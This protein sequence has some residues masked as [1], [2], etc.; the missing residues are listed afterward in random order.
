MT[1]Q[2]NTRFR[3]SEH[4]TKTRWL[5]VEDALDIG[6]LR[7][8]AG[9]YTRGNGASHTAHHFLDLA[10]ARVIF[11]DLSLGRVP[12]NGKGAYIEYKGSNGGD[13]GTA[14]SALSRWTGSMLGWLYSPARCWASCSA[15][16][17]FW[18]NLS[19]RIGSAPICLFRHKPAQRGQLP[20]QP[21]F[22]PDHFLF[23]SFHLLA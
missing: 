7:L 11:F 19:M 13:A 16:C 9:Q 4:I 6:K 1:D 2:P 12:D 3:I 22:T 14:T 15:S 17:A 20:Q 21:L 5:H 8:F 18:V 10:D 23:K